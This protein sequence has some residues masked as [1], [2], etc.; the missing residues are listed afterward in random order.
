ME[1]SRTK[2]IK[3][4]WDFHWLSLK[5]IIN[6]IKIKRKLVLKEFKKILQNRTV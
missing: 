3:R 1:T 2:R 6:H 5:K 4:M